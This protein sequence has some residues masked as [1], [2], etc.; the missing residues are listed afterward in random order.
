[1]HCRH[2]LAALAHPSRDTS[3]VQVRLVSPEDVDA[4]FLDGWSRLAAHSEPNPFFEPQALLPAARYLPGGEDVALLVAE[5]DGELAFLAPVRRQRRFQKVPVPT[6]ATWAHDYCF[7]GTPLAAADPAV[8]ATAV[9]QVVVACRRGGWWLGLPVLGTDGGV[10]EALRGHRAV[11]LTEWQRPVV[12]RRMTAGYVDGRISGRHRKNL[13]RQQRNLAEYL[14]EEVR[15]VDAAADGELDYAIDELLRVEASGWKGRAGTAMAGI[16]GHAEFFRAMCR[17]FAETHQLEV[18]LY[19]SRGRVVAA[20]CN[21]RSGGTVFHFKI[22]YDES[23]RRFSPGTILDLAMIETFH[24]DDRLSM[25]D[26]CVAPGPS[27]SEKAYP[28]RRPLGDLV[29]PIGGRA[30]A[31]AATAARSALRLWRSRPQRQPASVGA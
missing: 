19:G 14:G 7:L 21:I 25:I 8:A 20:Q 26:S 18:W 17:G 28:D 4:A 1:M 27:L 3:C 6:V 9:D 23:L 12:H 15:L 5:Q 2:R 11:T 31:A 22:A 10:A 30:A 24:A 16:R 29:V 13:R